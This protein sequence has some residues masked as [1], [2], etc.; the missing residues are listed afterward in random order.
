MSV[1][2]REGNLKYRVLSIDGGGI[3]GTFPA[4]FLASLEEELEEPIGEYFDLIAGTSTGGIIAIGLAMGLRASEILSFFE[5]RGPE[6]FEASHGLFPNRL[7]QMY[8]CCRQLIRPKYSSSALR[9]VLKEILGDKC[10]GDAKHRLLVPAWAS[11]E[12]SVHVHK[13]AHHPRLTFD[14][15]TL[16]LDAALATSAAPTYFRKH[17]NANRI[18]LIDGGIWANNP[19]AIAVVESIAVLGWP[20]DSL[21][22]LSLG[23]L[24]EIYSISGKEGRVP[25]VFKATKLFSDGQS[26]AAMGM[27]ELLTD[28]DPKRPTIH[29][30]D[31][32]VPSNSHKMD[33][34]SAI[35]ELRGLGYAK[36]RKEL[37]HLKPIFFDRPAE[38]FIPCHPLKDNFS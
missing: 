20:R 2:G 8:L 16:A 10:I 29:R 17:I 30:V 6:I 34:T 23:C 33:N 15:K 24:D 25:L 12:R 4:S 11:D 32:S 14:Y 38:P 5:E 36:A 13:T 7:R 37:S 35:S 22:V 27:A 28:H 26:K 9:S 31:H 1:P 3:L 18:G 21:R 19:I